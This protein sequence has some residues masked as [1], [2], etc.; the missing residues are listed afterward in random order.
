V[1]L[2][3]SLRR[4]PTAG[5]LAF[6]AAA[7][8]APSLHAQSRGAC[9]TDRLVSTLV[10]AGLGGAVA[11]IPATVVHRHDQATSHR[12]VAVSISGG[13]L[14]GFLAANRDHPC[15]PRADSSSTAGVVVATR[16]SHALRGAVAGVLVGGV[17]GAVG[18]TFYTV[19]CDLDRPCDA[20]R[21]RL[22]L[23]IFSAAEGAAACGL[24]GGLMGWAWPV[25]R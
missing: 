13:A 20:Y 9:G 4:L 17:L 7:A 25:H 11:A 24:L 6:I 22:G 21:T 16:S 18:S 19:G 1:T 14:V 23:T 3:F 8:W 15:A 10:G 2:T 5:I 12:I